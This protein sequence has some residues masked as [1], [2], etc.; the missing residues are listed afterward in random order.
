MFSLPYQKCKKQDV[1]Q[2]FGNIQPDGKPHSGCDFSPYNGYGIFLLAP[3]NVIIEKVIDSLVL[4][5][6]LDPLER[7]YGI[8]MRSQQSQNIYHLFW[9]CLPVFPVRQGDYAQKG[10]IVAQMG[11]SGNVR[12][13]GAYVPLNERTKT[14]GGTHLHWECYRNDEGHKIYFDPLLYL[15]WDTP[16]KL[17]ADSIVAKISI[18]TQKIKGILK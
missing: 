7:G 4:S 11:N 9:H 1:S 3:E 18:L 16:V 17:G 2:R 12:R 13:N 8:L 6:S 15:D 10:Q 5:N 14:K